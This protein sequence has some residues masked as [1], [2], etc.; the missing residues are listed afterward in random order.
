MKELIQKIEQAAF[1][2][3]ERLFDYTD[4]DTISEVEDIF[5]KHGEDTYAITV[6]GAKRTDLSNEFEIDSIFIDWYEKSD[7]QAYGT[8]ELIKELPVEI[9]EL[10]KELQHIKTL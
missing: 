3:V 5:V 10:N 6:Y 1:N 4:K 9:Q 8:N 2:E 7:I